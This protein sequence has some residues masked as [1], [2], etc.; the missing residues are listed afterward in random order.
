[1]IRMLVPIVALAACSSRHDAPHW[2]TRPLVQAEGKAVPSQVPF[3]IRVPEGYNALDLPTRFT[4][5]RGQ[6]I[7]PYLEVEIFDGEKHGSADELAK[8]GNGVQPFARRE[9][10]DGWAFAVHD[11]KHPKDEGYLVFGAKLVGDRELECVAR[12]TPLNGEDVKALIPKIED[13]CFS[14]APKTP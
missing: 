2:S 8:L 1:M 5:M 12:A 7:T 14:V 13:M 10:A 3:T 4:Y 11:P 9:Q 6:G